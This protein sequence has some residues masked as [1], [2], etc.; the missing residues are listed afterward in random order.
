[1]ANAKNN[2][3][4]ASITA[5]LAAIEAAIVGME[6]AGMAADFIDSFRKDALKD[7]VGPIREKI[8]NDLAAHVATFDLGEDLVAL[9]GSKIRLT[10]TVA[11]DGTLNVE[12]KISGTR[13][14]SRSASKS[15]GNVLIVNEKGFDSFA[16]LTRHLG[17]FKEH[18]SQ[19]R[20]YRAL[21]AADPDNFPAVQTVPA[22]SF[23]A[24]EH[25]PEGYFVSKNG[26][27]VRD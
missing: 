11:D 12:Q 22:D 23:D 4:A 13:S 18:D 24:D 26:E 20:V 1:M 2:T 7:L 9:K 14:G 19:A 15:A 27:A 10:V 3:A 21:S 5:K 25:A 16:T 17:V 6:D 8:G